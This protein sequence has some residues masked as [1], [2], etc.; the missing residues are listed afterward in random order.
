M[1]STAEERGVS[2]F[3]TDKTFQRVKTIK[4]GQVAP[5]VHLHMW[6]HL[7]FLLGEWT[8][9]TRLSA[10]HIHSGLKSFSSLLSLPHCPPRASAWCV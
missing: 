7:A 3:L 8:S 1:K 9:S 4:V 6:R 2:A 10:A 5:Q